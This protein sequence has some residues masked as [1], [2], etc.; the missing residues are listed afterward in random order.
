[1][2]VASDE[3]ADTP[4]TP[5]RSPARPS[6]TAPAHH[7]NN[8]KPDGEDEIHAN[9]STAVPGRASQWEVACA[10]VGRW[11]RAT[12]EW[13]EG[14][15]ERAGMGGQGRR[16]HYD[17]VS[18]VGEWPPGEVT[19]V[20][21]W[22]RNG[23]ARWS[24]T[25]PPTAGPSTDVTTRGADPSAGRLSLCGDTP[26]TRPPPI[27]APDAPFPV[28]PLRGW[29]GCG[30]ANSWEKTEH[31]QQKKS[32]SSPIVTPVAHAQVVSQRSAVSH[33][34]AVSLSACPYDHP[35]GDTSVLYMDM[36]TLSGAFAPRPL[37][38]D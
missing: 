37:A 17:G 35:S 30:V 10:G 22:R 1:M 24:G 23:A 15:W 19:P 13:R 33:S 25:P 27:A 38:V 2:R 8:K 12:A 32:P 21:G 18:R 29:C 28:G 31:L 5:R 6:R 16:P 20:G 9:A 14:V 7:T 36:D 4:Q 26:Q 3:G 11:R 34:R